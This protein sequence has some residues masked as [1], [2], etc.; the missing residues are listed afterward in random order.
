MSFRLLRIL[1]LLL[2]FC[3][4]AFSDSF[5]PFDV[6]I[7]YLPE[8]MRGEWRNTG[9]KSLGRG[10]GAVELF[11]M[12]DEDSELVRIDVRIYDASL[13][14]LELDSESISSFWHKYLGYPENIMSSVTFSGH[15]TVD[16]RAGQLIAVHK[17][18]P[19]K[20][21]YQIIKPLHMTFEHFSNLSSHSR[22]QGRYYADYFSRYGDR[23]S[24]CFFEFH[25][26]LK[27]LPSIERYENRFHGEG[28][29]ESKKCQTKLLI[30]LGDS[31]TPT[32]FYRFASLL[33]IIASIL[34]TIQIAAV[35]AQVLYNW[36]TK[37]IFYVNVPT[38]FV[39][40][41]LTMHNTTVFSVFADV[42]YTVSGPFIAA[43]I[44]TGIC[45]GAYAGWLVMAWVMQR[46]KSINESTLESAVLLAATAVTFWLSYLAMCFIP[47]ALALLSLA[48]FAFF[49]PQ[50]VYNRESGNGARAI[51][52]IF[53]SFAVI[54][55][56]FTPVYVFLLAPRSLYMQARP[57]FALSLATFLIA[58]A[59][60][61]ILQYKQQTAVVP[62]GYSTIDLVESNE[63]AF[64]V[65]E[66]QIKGM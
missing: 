66:Q 41:L 50:I 55:N 33:G 51:H 5:N 24:S 64:L 2:P 60:C 17:D 20:E 18:T 43:A 13:S 23:R 16:Y 7:G 8:Q 3:S 21:A 56:M 47:G 52:P 34:N 37:T 22:N 58:Q 57:I 62:S 59:I 9:R 40:L 19:L 31:S 12:Q 61:L 6:E 49:V 65:A 44:P 45:A 30:T 46:Q 42:V 28:T 32:N 39:L 1:M 38:V 63:S 10:N 54:V 27:Q 48:L 25:L 53:A 4:A 11:K 36:R 14:D 15:G 35:C 26:K 29:L